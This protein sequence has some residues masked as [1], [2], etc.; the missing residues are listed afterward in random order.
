VDVE[1]CA[2][3]AGASAGEADV[4]TVDAGASAGDA[5][6]SSVDAGICAVDAGASSV[7][8]VAVW[9]LGPIAGALVDDCSV[10][11]EV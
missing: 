1:V 6:D 4:C 11:G 5:G 3:G 7:D 10:V 8:A 2:V 9:A